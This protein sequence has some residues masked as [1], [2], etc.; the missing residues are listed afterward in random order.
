MIYDGLENLV[1][2]IGSSRDKAAAWAWTAIEKAPDELE[3]IY[4][5]GWLGKKIVN[6]PTDDMVREWRTWQ[7]DRPFVERVEAV[8]KTFKVRDKVTTA[9][10]WS[11]IFGS[12]AIIV[13]VNP[14]LG[15]PDEPLDWARVS[16]GDMINLVVEIYPYLSVAEWNADL[17]SDR[18]GEPEVYRYSPF[19]R[20]GAVLPAGGSF[21]LA[22]GGVM[23]HA[24]RVIPF[25]GVE[26]TP[27]ASLRTTGWGDSVYTALETAIT[28]AGSATATIVSLMTEAKVDVVTVPELANYLSTEES[29][30]KLRKRFSLAAMLK[31]INNTLLL[32]EG[33]TYEQKAIQFSGLADIHMRLLQEVSGAADIPVTRLLGQS[34][35]GLS[36]TGEADLRNYYDH[37][38]ARQKVEIRPALDRLDTILFAANGVDLPKGIDWDFAPL[39]QETR[40]QKATTLGKVATAVKTLNDTG[41]LDDG[42]FSKSVVSTLVEGDYFPSL[43]SE[44]EEAAAGEA[45]DPSETETEETEGVGEEA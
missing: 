24:S 10:R 42:A 41:L 1:A 25:A 39:W 20:G 11:R 26:L 40:D 27:Y 7:A 3:A 45:E 23:V 13:V 33:E 22:L 9:K 35:A 15:R 44:M 37:I 30:A 2:N 29:E 34:P 14:R 18:F 38:R 6:V 4:R 5:G 16:D 32:G 19:R 28:S 43:A 21:G 12:A 17:A 31:S 36:S 8:E